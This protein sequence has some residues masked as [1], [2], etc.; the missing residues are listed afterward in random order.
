M[1]ARFSL[2]ITRAR[3]RSSR[4]QLHQHRPDC[5]DAQRRL[6]QLGTVLYDPYTTN[7][8]T[9]AAAVA[10]SGKPVRI[11]PS[12][13]NPVGQAL[14]DL[15]PLPESCPARSTTL[16]SHPSRS[17]TPIST[18]SESTT[19]FPTTT[20]C[21]GTRRFR[22]FA[23]LKPAPLGSAGGCCQ[24]FGS[25]INGLEQSHAAGWT[26]IF[27][28]ALVNEFRFAFHPVEHQHH[29]RRRRARPVRSARHPQRQ[30]RGRLFLR[31]VADFHVRLRL[32]RKHGRLPIRSRNRPRQHLQL[33]RRA[34]LGAR[35]SHH[36]IR[37]RT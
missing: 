17:L 11:P 25:N 9:A 16:Y 29:A 28:P 2:S 31:P 7:P 14:V 5:T 30:P 20:T 12:R 10:G 4:R 36:E 19:A 37:R 22:M 27:S 21:S 3:G 26:H 24:G 18:T 15:L 23:F 34:E 35:T 32:R 8:Q 1:T 33:Q 13:I 6:Q